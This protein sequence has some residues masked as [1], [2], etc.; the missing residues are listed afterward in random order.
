[1][2]AAE[3]LFIDLIASEG[4]PLPEREYRFAPPRRWRFDA[5]WP[6]Q[7]VAVEIDGK[8][9]GGGRHT[10]G[11]GAMGDYEKMMFALQQGWT[12]FRI[13]SLWLRDGDRMLP[14]GDDILDTLRI[15]LGHLTR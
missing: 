4:L 1:M 6:L 11:S 5:A 12:V 9:Y 3:D 13:P 8:I 10:R 7:L 15:L 14:R 2:S